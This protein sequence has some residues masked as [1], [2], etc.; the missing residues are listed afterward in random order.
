MPVLTFM[1]RWLFAARVELIDLKDAY[2]FRRPLVLFL[3]LYALVL[4]ILNQ[5]GVFS[6]PPAG[7]ATLLE[8]PL[9]LRGV[10]NAHPVPN[11]RGCTYRLGSEAGSLFEAMG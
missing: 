10:I 5:R 9:E 3:I 11:P 2:V 1:T 6:R 7:M 4:L 8:Q